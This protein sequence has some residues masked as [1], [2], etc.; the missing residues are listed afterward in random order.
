MANFIEITTGAQNSPQILNTSL[1]AYVIPDGV[2]GSHIYLNSDGQKCTGK[3]CITVP[4]SYAA[5]KAL[6]IQ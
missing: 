6:L 5:I 2:V 3:A 1:I 4:E